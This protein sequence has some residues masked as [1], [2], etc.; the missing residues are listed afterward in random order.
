[1]SVYAELEWF[2]E[3]GLGGKEYRLSQMLADED[4]DDETNR[5]K[6]L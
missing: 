4:W 6:V 2:D 5:L 1:M 3:V